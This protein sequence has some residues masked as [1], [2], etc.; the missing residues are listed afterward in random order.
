M[1]CCAGL[2][3]TS[4][5]KAHWACLVCGIPW[6]LL[7]QHLAC[8][9]SLTGA[10]QRLGLAEVFTGRVSAEDGMDTCAQQLL[11]AAIQLQRPPNR[12]VAF[13][14]SPVGVTAAHN[15]TMKVSGCL[16]YQMHVCLAFQSRC[17]AQRST[18]GLDHVPCRLLPCWAL[19]QRGSCG[20]PTSPAPAWTS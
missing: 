3:A 18:F 2:S 10:L 4:H 14:A 5:P 1:A 7:R 19:T 12:C 9:A 11:A 20:R 15:C 6:P 16:L 17:A 13:D 8:R